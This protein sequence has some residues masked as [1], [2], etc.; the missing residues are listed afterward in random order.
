MITQLRKKLSGTL[1]HIF[2]VV[3]VLG[4]LGIFSLPMI[5]KQGAKP[6]ALKING[7]T[8]PQIIFERE[9]SIQTDRIA[10][11]KNKYGQFA[12]MLFQSMGMSTDPKAL[13]TDLLTKKTLLDDFACRNSI[14]IAHTYANQKVVDQPFAQQFLGDT[15][16]PFLYDKD[17]SFQ[18]M[19]VRVY[20]QKLGLS[21]DMFLS[22]VQE[23]IERQIAIAL[24]EHT[25]HIPLYE[26]NLFL[27][28][29]HGTKIIDYLV[30]DRKDFVEKAKKTV[31]S[32]QV[33]QQYFDEKNKTAQTY[34]VPEKRDVTVWTFEAGLYDETVTDDQLFSY[35]EKNKNKEFLEQQSQ[36]TIRKIVYKEQ[37][38]NGPSIATL[39]EELAK[40]PAL[41]AEYAKK[42]SQDEPSAKKGG[43]TDPLIYGASSSPLYKAAF[44]LKEAG[45]VSPVI[46]VDN[47]FVIVQLVKKE[48][49]KYKS[50]ETVK[51]DIA[52]SIKKTLFKS[53]FGK[54]LRNI[55]K[56]GIVDT[57]E[58][59][60]LVKIHGG[61]KKIVK[62]ITNTKK[63]DIAKTAF[64]ID[65]KNKG[66]V[67]LHE[68]QAQV[69]LL[70][71]IEPTYL[72]EFNDVSDTVKNDWY[73]LQGA[74]ALQKAYQEIQKDIA[75]TSLSEIA[76][77]FNLPLKQVTF[78]GSEDKHAFKNVEKYGITY[79]DIL[80]LEKKDSFC[81][82]MTANTAFFAICT[83]S[84]L[85]KE[86]TDISA[87][88]KESLERATKQLIIEG[89]IA[90]LY[91]DAKIET[92]ESL[93]IPLEDYMI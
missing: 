90:S 73:E 84:E 68:N 58:L 3:S 86:H 81:C 32:M 71:N 18:T 11:I 15:V 20:L 21:S 38:V 24:V 14:K 78:K 77:R 1:T 91:R 52:L 56:D 59:Q 66:K 7:R 16:P 41:F 44:A 54:Q 49:K 9:V 42:Y 2:L 62:G 80:S 27:L 29:Q 39:Q 60:K 17:G 28:N 57:N 13:A 51:R 85:P 75:N 65:K 19:L 50:F 63:D 88:E 93:S 67:I 61:S 31:P 12:D 35:Y 45:D 43:L 48:P 92:N 55:L 72:P 33:L 82:S 74:L 5:V 53:H 8:I 37:P 83:A 79:E 46:S 22:K 34:F 10:E 40:K 76:L 26:Q 36:V 89:L 30:L 6:W 69:V 23:S 25:M 70:D 64:S 87:Q 47:S 4:L